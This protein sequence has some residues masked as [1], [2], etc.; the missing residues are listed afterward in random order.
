VN[1]KRFFTDAHLFPIFPASVVR[2]LARD[3]HQYIRSGAFLSNWKIRVLWL[4]AKLEKRAGFI[5]GSSARRT[6][7]RARVP[8]ERVERGTQ[9]AADGARALPGKTWTAVPDSP[10]APSRRRWY[11][12]TAERV[13]GS[14][15][16]LLQS[17]NG[18]RHEI[19]SGVK[20][21]G[22]D[23][24]VC[25]KYQKAVSVLFSTTYTSIKYQHVLSHKMHKRR[26]YAYCRKSAIN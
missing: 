21:R 6:C 15:G 19:S 5:T 1:K 13:R 26:I 12:A 24:T 2:T 23:Q 10:A 18:M 20:T 17:H 22:T 3:A 8:R 14:L 4:L 9:L 7:N 16:V 25:R 11:E